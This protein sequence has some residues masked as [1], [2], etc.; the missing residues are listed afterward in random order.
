MKKMIFLLA[1]SSLAACH[2]TN[3]QPTTTFDM[4]YSTTQ[5]LQLGSGSDYN[6]PVTDAGATMSFAPVKVAINAQQY[7]DKYHT[8]SKNVVTTYLG[9]V[10]LEIPTPGNHYFDFSDNLEL[11][12]SGNSQPEVLVAYDYSIPKGLKSINL[13]LAPGVNLKN[14]I[15]NDSITIR[16]STHVSYIPAPGAQIISTGVFQVTANP[17][18]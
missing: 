10:N 6:T 14:Y 1:V 5:A 7:F 17:V 11:Y 3:T 2:K 9:G 13:T 16:L 15:V 18:Q 4:Q 12:I 8:S